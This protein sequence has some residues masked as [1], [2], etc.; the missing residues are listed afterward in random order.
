[1][2]DIVVQQIMQLMMMIG[3]V[4]TKYDLSAYLLLHYVAMW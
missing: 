3:S 4:A 1:M 2:R